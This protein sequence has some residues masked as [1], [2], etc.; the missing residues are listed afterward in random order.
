[1]WPIPF[2]HLPTFSGFSPSHLGHPQPLLTW[3]LPYRFGTTWLSQVS[4]VYIN[5]HIPR[6]SSF[7]KFEL[8]EYFA[9]VASHPPLLLLLLLVLLSSIKT[10]LPL[11]VSL[12]FLET[13]LASPQQLFALGITVMRMTRCVSAHTCLLVLSP[14][15]A[16][17]ALDVTGES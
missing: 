5:H 13:P 14:S 16:A 3:V 9:T 6:P 8:V 1:M 12:L 7:L 17:R 2:H 11:R 4:E 10:P 15:S